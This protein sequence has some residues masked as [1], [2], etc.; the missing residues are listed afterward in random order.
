MDS[1]NGFGIFSLPD[2]S[3]DAAFPEIVVKAIDASAIDARFW[4][5][6]TNLTSLG[7]TLTATD[8]V[9]GKSVV[10]DHTTPFCGTADIDTFIDSPWD[11]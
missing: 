2:V 3:G 4:F 7:Y 9:T 10:Y 8:T 6:Q 1:G 11:Y 5:F